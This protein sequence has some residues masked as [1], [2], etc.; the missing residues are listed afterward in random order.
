M[1]DQRFSREAFLD[2]GLDS[3]AAK[4]LVDE[5]HNE[6]LNIL[7]KS[8]DSALTEVVSQLNSMGHKLE[9]FEPPK[10]GDIHYA[11]YIGDQCNLRLA[12]DIVVSAGFGYTNYSDPDVASRD[13]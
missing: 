12:A 13:G 3:D 1:L 10:P 5:L 11:H 6:V 8:V 9:L 7:H 4:E 2:G